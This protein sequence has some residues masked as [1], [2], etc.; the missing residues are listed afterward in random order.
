MQASNYTLHTSLIKMQTNGEV[1]WKQDY[2]CGNDCRTLPYNLI[3]THDGGFF[4]GCNEYYHV[5]TQQ[6]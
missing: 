3:S 6:Q 4:I 2:Y 5:G 1:L